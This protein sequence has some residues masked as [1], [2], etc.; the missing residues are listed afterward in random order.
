MKICE[1][2]EVPLPTGE[3][4]R[5]NPVAAE[6]LKLN[7]SPSKWARRKDNVLVG[8]WQKTNRNIDVLLMQCIITYS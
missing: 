4:L 2:P 3:E 5:I 1:D 8:K 6:I 7:S